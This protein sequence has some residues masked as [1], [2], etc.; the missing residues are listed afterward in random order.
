MIFFLSTKENLSHQMK[1]I[2]EKT[3]ITQTWEVSSFFLMMVPSAFGKPV[4]NTF[5]YKTMMK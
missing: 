3:R 1:V 4:S 2:G 5:S